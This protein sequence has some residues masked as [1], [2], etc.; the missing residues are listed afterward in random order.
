MSN[1]MNP[2]ETA[3]FLRR[4][5][6]GRK[7]AAAR[8]RQQRNN[9]DLTGRLV[10]YEG[11]LYKVAYHHKNGWLSLDNKGRTLR[12][13]ISNV[14]IQNAEKKNRGFLPR[15][16]FDRYDVVDA[17]S[18]KIFNRGLQ[19]LS[20]ARSKARKRLGSCEIKIVSQQTGSTVQTLKNPQ[21]KP[22]RAK[23]PAT[24]KKA[25]PRTKRRRLNP[26]QMAEAEALYEQFHGRP[27]NRTIEY[28]QPHEYRSELAELGKLLELRFD[29]DAE[30]ESVP[31][32]N[33][34]PCQVTCTPDGKNIYFVG[35]DMKIDLDGLGIES[36][37]D[38]VELGPCTYIKYHTRKGF[39]DFAP[40]DYF[41]EFGEE[42]DVLPVLLYDSINRALFL[43]GGD[44]TV[45][46]EGI[47]N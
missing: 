43:A 29:L 18:G 45:R 41:H 9:T 34:G 31:L 37:K 6:R 17:S 47:V 38:Y 10:K 46:P 2:T 4:M 3:A 16:L 20:G 14:T 30:N 26:E 5:A 8:G 1:R 19:T 42:N 36:G 25:T 21:A 27:A 35:G 28:D 39:H 12:V 33:F 13:H 11:H 15:K 32:K 22:S 23:N 7:E 24:A 44:Y 40:I